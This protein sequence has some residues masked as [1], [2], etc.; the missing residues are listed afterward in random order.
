MSQIAE[1][2]YALVQSG[3]TKAAMAL[4][5]KGINKDPDDMS[6][7]MVG[8]SVLTRE[9]CWGMAFNLLKRIAQTHPTPEV[10]NNLGMCASSLASQTGRDK[11]LD[12]A[13]AYLRR[14]FKKNQGYEVTANLSL[15]MLHK[16]DL[17]ASEHFAK[18]CLEIEPGN[19]S[20]RETLGYVH[21]HR[22]EWY[23]GFGNFEF[24][25]GGKYRTPPKGKYWEQGFKGGRLFLRGEQGIGDEISYASVIP[26]AANDN[27]IVFECDKRLEGLF[28]RS[29]PNVTVIGERFA[30]AKTYDSEDFDRV[31]LVG[32]LF[33]Q[34]RRKDEDFPRTPFLVPD[35]ERRIQWR[36]L[37]DTLPGKKVGIAWTGG[38]ENTFRHRR[39]FALE[40]LLPI[41]KTPGITWVSLQY[42]DSE[43]ELEVMRERHGIDIKSWPRA[44][45]KG[46]DYDETAALMMELDAV[47]STTT[48]VVHLAG[49]IGKKAYVL[50]PKKNRWFYSSDTNKH[51]WYDSVELFKQADKWPVEKLADRL[52]ADLCG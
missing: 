8:A 3:N 45:G 20:A 13:E 4:V 40:T 26:D 42:S 16:L 48:A 7:L 11:Y 52:K 35:P 38:L 22:G 10:L 21:L 28:R 17:A 31:A 29:F 37:L 27:E 36:A 14:A 23:Q 12:E 46:V 34:Y 2:A 5:N 39:S 6:L 47:V 19:L 18:K 33:M 50:V 24:A 9:Q 1:E 43:G 51:R 49:A 44:T 25:L 30:E 32:S 15:V 41:L